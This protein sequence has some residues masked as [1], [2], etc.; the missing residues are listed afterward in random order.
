M[1]W[2][3]PLISLLAMLVLPTMGFS[4]PHAVFPTPS[5]LSGNVHLASEK[6]KC[7][8]RCETRQKSCVRKMPADYQGHPGRE[9][10]WKNQCKSKSQSCFSQC[11]CGGDP[12]L[13]KC[14]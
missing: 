6:G 12:R 14:E 2:K 11:G 7:M 5:V 4:Q 3:F 9:A 8:N 1:Y 13:P 10:Q